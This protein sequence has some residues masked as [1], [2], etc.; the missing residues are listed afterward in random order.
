MIRL[1]VPDLIRVLDAIELSEEHPIHEFVLESSLE[2]AAHGG[3]DGTRRLLARRSGRRIT[4]SELR[5]A[6]E[7]ASRIGQ[8]GEELI[9][10]YLTQLK[11]E[12]EIVGMEWT[13]REN[14]ISPYDF[15][16]DLP[17]EEQVV[18]D[19]KATPGDFDRPIHISSAELVEIAMGDLRYDLYR[20]YEIENDSSAKLRVATDLRSFA[21]NIVKILEQ[22]P[23]A[24]KSDGIS[25]IPSSLQF[26]QEV[27]HVEIDSD[28]N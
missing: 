6:R 22:L 12:G 4:S 8:M 5:I 28:V 15:K 2:D 20:V 1:K 26:S 21:Q 10:A 23:D 9:Y 14:A 17:N 3:Y 18:L 19:V 11:E 7:S 13:A 25:V 27:L 24:V 16:I